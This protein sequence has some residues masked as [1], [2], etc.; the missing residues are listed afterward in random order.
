MDAKRLKEKLNSIDMYVDYFNANIKDFRTPYTDRNPFDG[1]EVLAIGCDRKSLEDIMSSTWLRNV[2][3][4]LRNTSTGELYRCVAWV[5]QMDEE[6]VSVN[7][8]EDMRKYKRAA[9]AFLEIFEP[10]FVKNKDVAQQFKL[11]PYSVKDE[12]QKYTLRYFR[13]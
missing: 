8:I 7:G 5:R 9:P 1:F 3:F 11:V 12:T 2:G 4:L 10:W 6:T 13:R